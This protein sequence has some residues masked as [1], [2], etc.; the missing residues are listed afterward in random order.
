M[1]MLSSKDGL[2][3]KETMIVLS[4]VGSFSIHNIQYS[5]HALLYCAVATD[6]ILENPRRY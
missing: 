5:V 3:I 6:D 2:I 4:K 1:M